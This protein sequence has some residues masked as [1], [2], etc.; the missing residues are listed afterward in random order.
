[1]C[2]LRGGGLGG[3]GGLL[4][5]YELPSCFYRVNPS[6]LQRLKLKTTGSGSP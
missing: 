3:D 6:N 5:V 4:V 2:A 1:M